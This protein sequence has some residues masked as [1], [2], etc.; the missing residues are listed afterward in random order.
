[1]GLLNLVEED[2]GIGLAPDPL[3]ELA[4]LLVAHVARGR[5]D[6]AGDGV[7]L[8]ILRHVDADDGAL[9]AKHGLRQGFAQ[10]R[11]AHARGSQE[12]EGA[13]GPLGVLQPHPAPADGPG[14]GLHGL[15]LAHHPLV[16]NLFHPQK[17]AALV[18]RQAGDGDAR[19]ARHHGG[20]VL[21]RDGAVLPGAGAPLLP[22]LLHL[23]L[24]VALNVPELGGG[25]I[26]LTLDGGFLVLGQ[27][28][29]FLLQGFQLRGDLL[30]LHADPGRGLVH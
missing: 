4:A 29:D 2:H 27:G 24:V 22:L 28:G 11:L 9:V 15:V 8:H 30:L 18:L 6:E 1:M 19:P 7:A 23:V 3:R 10:L 13:R 14:H 12:Q 17:P 25:L 5:A 21:R 20:D 16:E 26:V